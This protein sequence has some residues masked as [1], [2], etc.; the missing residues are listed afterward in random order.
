MK[1]RKNLAVAGVLSLLVV[2]GLL[3]KVIL[4]KTIDLKKVPVAAVTIEPRTRIEKEMIVYKEIP[5]IFTDESCAMDE[6]EI[7]DKITEIEGKI[8]KGSLF[9]KQMLFDEK[10]L[11]DYPALK[12]KEGQSSFSLGTDL[13]KSSGNSLTANQKVDLY[14]TIEQKKEKP[15]TDLLVSSIRILSVKDRKGNLMGTKNSSNVPYVINL[16][17]SNE[18]VELL[19]IASKVGTIDLYAVAD[20][21]KDEECVLNE[22]SKVMELLVEERDE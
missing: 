6:S 2:N 10:E 5:S 7:L 13:L 9:Y 12:L 17:V 3:F 20:D 11:P 21:R 15:V 18:Y 4:D 19:K 22:A 14:V 1:N 8:P 16:A